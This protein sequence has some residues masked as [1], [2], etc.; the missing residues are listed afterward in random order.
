MHALKM[1][2]PEQRDLANA[3]AMEALSNEGDRPT[4][5]TRI[6]GVNPNE[7]GVDAN[8]AKALLTPLLRLKAAT[9]EYSGRT[10]PVRRR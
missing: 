8:V 7:N 9:T 2:G 4:G 6:M 10:S 5:A 1:T 3:L